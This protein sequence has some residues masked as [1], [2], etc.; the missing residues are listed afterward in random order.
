[1]LNNIKTYYPIQK[2]SFMFIR[3]NATTM[4]RIK[5]R[6]TF[7]FIITENKVVQNLLKQY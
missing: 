6:S 5:L 4:H 1:M 2:C 7:Y 3:S